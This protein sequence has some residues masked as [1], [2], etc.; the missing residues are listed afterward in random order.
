MFDPT[1]PGID[2]FTE[3][4]IWM[5]AQ[6]LNSSRVTA[7]FGDRIMAHPAPRDL[8]VYPILTY[9]ALFAQPDVHLVGGN[10]LW[11]VVPFTVRGIV[12][13]L[14]QMRL[15]EGVAAIHDALHNQW[16]TTDNAT[17]WCVRDK[18]FYMVELSDT[19]H[20]LHKGGMYLCT[21][22]PFE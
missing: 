8:T 7:I 2:E 19:I 4:Q 9:D 12:D 15:Q 11:S 16:G 18:P 3:A 1:S 17:V 10:I 22:R 21:V 5:R 14:D 20:Y 13:G 6:L